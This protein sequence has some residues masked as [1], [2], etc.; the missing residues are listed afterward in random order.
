MISISQLPHT[1]LLR[2]S[3]HNWKQDITE[4]KTGLRAAFTTCLEVSWDQ[5][6]P[7]FACICDLTLDLTVNDA[8]WTVYYSD[9]NVIWIHLKASRI[10]PFREATGMCI[11]IH[12]Y[13]CTLHQFKADVNCCQS[14]STQCAHSKKEWVKTAHKIILTYFKNNLVC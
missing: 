7:A 10:D 9:P 12:K 14:F 4:D 2:D 11:D 6:T 3:R 13:F 8:T 1:E 5:Q